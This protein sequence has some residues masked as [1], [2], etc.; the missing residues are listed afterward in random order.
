M[1]FIISFPVDLSFMR[2]LK[3]VNSEFLMNNFHLDKGLRCLISHSFE[4]LV[5]NQFELFIFSFVLEWFLR[6]SRQ[7]KP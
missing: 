4:I 3:N 7:A 2:R 5:G 1:I 6:F